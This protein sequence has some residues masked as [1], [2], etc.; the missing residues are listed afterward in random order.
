MLD[1]YAWGIWGGYLICI[2]HVHVVVDVL[3]LL[4]LLLLLVLALVLVTVVQY[5]GFTIFHLSTCTHS[6]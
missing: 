4:F 2:S 6:C 1:F 3:L 5:L